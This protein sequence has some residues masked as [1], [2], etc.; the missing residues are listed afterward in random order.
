MLKTWTIF[1][2]TGTVWRACSITGAA[3]R[4]QVVSGQMCVYLMCFSYLESRLSY[5]CR[6]SYHYLSHTLAFEHRYDLYLKNIHLQ[7]HDMT[8]KELG[9]T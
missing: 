8:V 2:P 6:Q 9:K 5:L 4:L 7:G 3:E 1:L